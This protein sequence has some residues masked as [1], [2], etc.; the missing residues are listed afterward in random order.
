MTSNNT[1]NRNYRNIDISKI[2]Y[3]KL[4]K[5]TQV[6]YLNNKLQFWTPIMFSP[7]GI[8]KYYDNYLIKLSFVNK[9]NNESI[10]NEEFMDFIKNI[11]Y[12]HKDHL[13]IDDNY[14][15]TQIFSKKGYD[16]ML[17]LK[18]PYN[19][20]RFGIDFKNNKG[21]TLISTDIKKNMSL[22]ILVEIDNIWEFKDKYTCKFKCK[23]IIVN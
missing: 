20:D 2:S 6:T 4:D 18:I 16:P 14:Y 23:S 1:N 17:I 22:K 3:S 15:N 21:D 13:E 7:F 19:N 11:E 8:E 9:G 10:L 12:H 5:Y